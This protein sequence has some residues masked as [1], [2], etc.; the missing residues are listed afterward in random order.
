MLGAITH[1]KDGILRVQV[2]MSVSQNSVEIKQYPG[3]PRLFFKRPLHL[4]CF[5]QLKPAF[6]ACNEPWRGI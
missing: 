6:C 2:D 1:F 3:N 4:A 5:L